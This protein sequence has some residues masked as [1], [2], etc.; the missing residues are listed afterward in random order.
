MIEEGPDYKDFFRNIEESVREEERKEET[1]NKLRRVSEKVSENTDLTPIE[2]LRKI[3]GAVEEGRPKGVIRE[4]MRR[5]G[6]ARAERDLSGG[7]SLES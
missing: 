5:A 1:M 3:T 2:A 4:W 7:W 6:D